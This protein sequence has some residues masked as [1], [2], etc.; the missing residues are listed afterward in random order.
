MRAVGDRLGG[1]PAVFV[2]VDDR[3]LPAFARQAFHRIEDGLVLGGGRDEVLAPALRGV[4]EAL[5][6][7]V[8][9]FGRAGGEHDLPAL[10]ADR[11]RHLLAGVLNGLIGVP[12]E[13]VR[14]AR[15]V[16]VV[17]REVRQHRLDDPRVGP[18][19]GVVV[20]I[21]GPPHAQSLISPSRE[22][23]LARDDHFHALIVR[24]G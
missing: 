1:D 14:D 6:G 9:R 8:V 19:R 12:A 7:E 13:A 16:A 10:G 11:P 15:G 24:P 5:D 20:E 2:A 21:H 3:D 18:G 23:P 17:L 4:G 22:G